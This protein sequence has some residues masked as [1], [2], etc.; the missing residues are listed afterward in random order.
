V[1]FYEPQD[2]TIIIGYNQIA[3]REHRHRCQAFMSYLESKMTKIEI[4]HLNYI[5]YLDMKGYSGQFPRIF[6]QN[7]SFIQFMLDNLI[8]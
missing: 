1:T 7:L 6:I 8:S 2:K 5:N 4:S 3:S